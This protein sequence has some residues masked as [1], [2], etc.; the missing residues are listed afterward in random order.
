MMAHLEKVQILSMS[1][2][3]LSPFCELNVC[4]DGKWLE[5]I[6]W[7]GNKYSKGQGEAIFLFVTKA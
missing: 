1:L 2:R 4:T 7:E 3:Q 6:K 5:L